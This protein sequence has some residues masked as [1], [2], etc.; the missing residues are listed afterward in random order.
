MAANW[1]RGMMR[2][3]RIANHPAEVIEVRDFTPW[4]RRIVFRSPE[5]TTAV[6]GFPTLWLRLWAPHPA[7]G[8]GFVV[9]RG[10]TFVTL[11]PQ[12]Q[13][14]SLDFVLHDVAG[15]AGD[16]AKQVSVGERTE[17]ALTPARVDIPD[18]T[19]TLV[20]AGDST[21]LPAINSWLEV[22]PEEVTTRVFIEEDRADRESLPQA[23]H[24]NGTWEWVTRE[25]DRGAALAQAVRRALGSG[26]GAYAWGA[27]E[28]TLVKHLRSVFREHLGLDRSHH[29]TQFYWIEG[30]ATG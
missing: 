7:K 28:K 19:T 25:G 5:V 17:V 3:L 21:A 8:E 13:T 2:L 24:A 18:G 20:L 9:Q 15:P 16:W 29:F 10:Y 12:K 23:P 26:E 27:G 14:F 11:D 6:E 4:Y 22:V 30:K 1:Q